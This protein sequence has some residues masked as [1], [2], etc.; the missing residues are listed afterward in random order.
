M[1][2]EHARRQHRRLE[3]QAAAMGFELIPVTA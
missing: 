1:E 3:R 2:A